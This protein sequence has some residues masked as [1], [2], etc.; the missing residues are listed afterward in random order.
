M[1]VPSGV[2]HREAPERLPEAARTPWELRISR[3]SAG[4]RAGQTPWGAG[5]TRHGSPRRRGLKRVRG[6]AEVKASA[7]AREGC[8]PKGARRPWNHGRG[9]RVGG[10]KCLRVGGAF[11]LVF[12]RVRGCR[13]PQTEGRRDAATHHGLSIRKGCMS[14]NPMS[15]SG[16]SESARPKG[17]KPAERVRDPEGGACR[18]RQTRVMRIPSPMSLEGR[19]T[20]GGATRPGMAGEGA[21]A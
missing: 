8:A 16:P 21:V 12:L 17:A 10:L 14:E 4:S 19:E 1:P 13:A 11:D 20:P 18:V 6:S 5:P 2:V 3:R 7:T 9:T 15:G